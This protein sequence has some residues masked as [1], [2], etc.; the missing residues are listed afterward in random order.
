MEDREQDGRGAGC[1]I[2]GVVLILLPVLYVLGIGPANW[3]V[4][5]YPATRGPLSVIYT[6]V[7]IV[8]ENCEPIANALEWY[9]D[10]W[11]GGSNQAVPAAGPTAS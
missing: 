11:G 7:G 8:A 9:M 10:L 1:F 2:I 6:P 4:G 3:L 5:H